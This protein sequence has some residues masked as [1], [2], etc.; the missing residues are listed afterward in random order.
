V[1]REASRE[2]SQ[3]ASRGLTRALI[4]RDSAEAAATWLDIA[5]LDT[6]IQAGSLKDILQE[7]GGGG[8][9]T[10]FHHHS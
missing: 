7:G 9:E 4:V 3:E 6:A 1:G 8:G 5:Q 2:S 10:T